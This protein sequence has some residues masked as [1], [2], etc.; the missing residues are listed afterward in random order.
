[1]HDKC[2]EG[3]FCMEQIIE[4]YGMGMVMLL[5]GVSGVGFY[6]HLMSALVGV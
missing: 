1:M 2:E 3:R 5:L 4:E 6:A